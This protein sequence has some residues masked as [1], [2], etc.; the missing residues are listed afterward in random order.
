MESLRERENG[1][2]R[3]NFEREREKKYLIEKVV[4]GTPV[5][6]NLMER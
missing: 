4:V 3:G 6:T 5:F 1:E 2:K